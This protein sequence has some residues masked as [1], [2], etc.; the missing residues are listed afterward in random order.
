MRRFGWELIL[1]L[2]ECNDKI[3]DKKE[4]RRFIKELLKIIDMKPYKRLIAEHFGHQSEITAGYTAIQLIETSDITCH[5]GEF[6][7]QAFINLFSCKEFDDVKATKFIVDFFEGRI[8]QKMLL[9][10]G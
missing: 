8:K 7:K 10:R 9:P 5:F 2:E 6:Y 3:K 1:D 4:L